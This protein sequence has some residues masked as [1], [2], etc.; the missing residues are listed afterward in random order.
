MALILLVLSTFVTSLRFH[1]LSAGC[2][3]FRRETRHAGHVIRLQVPDSG[4]LAK[5]GLVVFLVGE[6]EGLLKSD[7]VR[8]HP[9]LPPALD[10]ATPQG[11]SVTAKTTKQL[12]LYFVAHAPKSTDAAVA[13]YYRV[14]G[15]ALVEIGPKRNAMLHSQPG[16]DGNDPQRKLRLMRWRHDNGERSEA[17][18]ISD[19]W[20]DEFVAQIMTLRREVVAARPTPP[21]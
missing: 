11:R 13:E 9:L 10:F 8:F 3:G 17:F 7:L 4:F 18:I 5:I 12:G 15:E 1:R 2:S 16:I 19:E 20:L 14:G 21:S 6:L